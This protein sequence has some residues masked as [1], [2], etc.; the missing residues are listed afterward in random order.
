MPGILVEVARFGATMRASKPQRKRVKKAQRINPDRVRSF[1]ENVI[2]EDV[3]AKR[4]LSLGNAVVGAMFAAS[5]SIH[6]I[7]QGLAASQRTMRKHGVKQVDRLL[8]NGKLDVWSIFAAW[9]LF[10]VGQR[11]EIIVALDWT[12]FDKDDHST[13]ALY[14]VTSHGRATPLLWRTVKKSELEDER[15]GHE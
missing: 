6:A 2:G 5:L 1:V 12:E 4:V 8:S 14:L 7:G 10:V 11:K 3:H 9:I 13:I 15:N